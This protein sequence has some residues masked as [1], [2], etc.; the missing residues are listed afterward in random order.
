MIPTVNNDE[1]YSRPELHPTGLYLRVMRS[2]GPMQVQ[3]GHFQLVKSK[4]PSGTNFWEDSFHL[5]YWGPDE[6]S[7]VRMMNAILP[8]PRK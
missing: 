3:L 6:A 1:Y 7:A 5:K 2:P 8:K 4:T